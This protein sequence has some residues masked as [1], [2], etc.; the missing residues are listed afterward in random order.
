[1]SP[2]TVEAKLASVYRKLGVHSRAQLG[3]AQLANLRSSLPEQM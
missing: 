1:M 3:G 2:K